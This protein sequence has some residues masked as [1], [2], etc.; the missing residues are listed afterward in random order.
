MSGRGM[1]RLTC[2]GC[3]VQIVSGTKRLFAVGPDPSKPGHRKIVGVS[4]DHQGCKGK[5]LTLLSGRGI[6]EVTW[7]ATP[8]ID[9]PDEVAEEVIYEPAPMQRRIPD[10]VRVTHSTVPA[11][12]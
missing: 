4:H 10:G 2:S 12:S 1:T 7:Q 6:S 8:K 11:H 5:L 3:H 9:Q